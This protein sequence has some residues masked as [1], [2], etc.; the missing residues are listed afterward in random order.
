VATT[1]EQHVGYEATLPYDGTAPPPPSA[2]QVSWGVQPSTVVQNVAIAPSPTVRIEDAGGVLDT[3]STAPVTVSIAVNPGGGTLTG[4]LTRNAVGGIATFNDL[5]INNV[6]VGYKLRA[7]SPGLVQEDSAAFEVKSAVGPATKLAFLAQPPAS[8]ADGAVFGASV[9]VEDASSVPVTSSTA[10]VTLYPSTSIDSLSAANRVLWLGADACSS[11]AHQDEIATWPDVSGVEHDASQSTSANRPLLRRHPLNGFPVARFDGTD[12]RML[13]ADHDDFDVLAG[14]GLTVF[15]VVD[16]NAPDGIIFQRFGTGGTPYYRL[17]VDAMGKPAGAVRGSGGGETT[18]TWGTVIEDAGWKVIAFRRGGGTLDIAVDGGTQVSVADGSS[19]NLAVDRQP[20]VG[21]H[22]FASTQHLNGRIAELLFFKARLSDA[23]RD[24]VVAYLRGK[25]E[26]GVTEV[27]TLMLIGTTRTNAVAGVASFSN[28][29]ANHKGTY[30]LRAASP[31]LTPAT[32]TAMVVEDPFPPPPPPYALRFP[33]FP[34]AQVTI[35]GK[36]GATRVLNGTGSDSQIAGMR[37]G[38]LIPGGYDEA[39]GQIDRAEFEANPNA[40]TYGATVT[41]RIAPG[42]PFAGTVVFEGSLRTPLSQPSNLV[43]LRA[44][45]WFHDLEER[46]DAMPW[47]TRYYAEWQS[48]DQEPYSKQGSFEKQQSEEI[49]AEAAKGE[50]RYRAQKGAT[51]K[52]PETARLL[53]WGEASG[54][55]AVS[56][57]Q[58]VRRLAGRVTKNDAMPGGNFQLRVRRYDEGPSPLP[59]GPLLT[60]TT[61]TQAGEGVADRARFVTSATHNLAVDQ[62]VE[63]KGCRPLAYNGTWKVLPAGLTATEFKCDIEKSGVSAA[64]TLGTAQF[65]GQGAIAASTG[66]GGNA[67]TVDSDGVFTTGKLDNALV[68]R[69]GELFDIEVTTPTQMVGIELTFVGAS[70]DL[71]STHRVSVTN[72]RLDGD[73]YRPTSAGGPTSVKT[74]SYTFSQMVRDLAHRM[75]W[76]PHKVV[77]TTDNGLPMWWQ[78]GPWTELLDFLAVAGTQA[79]GSFKWAVW[80]KEPPGATV[81]ITT[82]SQAGDGQAFYNTAS[83]HGFV[84][85]QIIEVAG[86]SVAGYN[87]TWGVT[88][89]GTLTFTAFP[90]TTGMGAGSGG[91]VRL[92]GGKPVVEFRDWRTAGNFKEWTVHGFVGPDVEVSIQSSDDV[93]S[94]VDVAWRRAGSPRLRHTR[95]PVI[96]EATGQNPLAGLDPPRERAYKVALQ[97]VV[98]DTTVPD[99]LAKGIAKDLGALQGAGTIRASW[100]YDGTTPKP[101]SMVRPGDAILVADWPSGQRTFRVVAVNCEDGG[102]AEFTVGRAPMDRLAHVLF[103]MRRRD[104]LRGRL[105]SNPT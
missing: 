67:G 5:K 14:G 62:R 105:P 34:P 79:L 60:L 76:L 90:T 11:L 61:A 40:Y 59:P 47:Q 13:L 71:N 1:Y 102:G 81:A 53:W 10:S 82:T 44:L 9:R 68:Y 73:A 6:G 24:A 93:Y 22:D 2:T 55:A 52:P 38:G 65:A 42:Q 70:G 103:W 95:V 20:A 100:V 63:I 69:G 46:E 26:L 16:V 58:A 33:Q 30:T 56:S 3:S 48:A 18:A 85:G 57:P 74:D 92:A 101:A 88:P 94:V 21:F 77:E 41:L 98:S 12:D 25:Y 8:V 27:P 51:M 83:P 78:G 50:L 7:T 87:G 97:E 86:V 35:K 31:T 28:V 84:K 66:F 43:Q 80:E 17:W 75:G 49:R 29:G 64:T 15:A 104:V 54:D 72:L 91:T 39:T 32:S 19:G 96:D 23:D 99:A 4:T 45:G 36:N 89:T 37:W